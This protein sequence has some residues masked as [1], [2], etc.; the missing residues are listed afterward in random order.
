MAIKEA[1]GT[2]IINHAV[3][4]TVSPV[5]ADASKGIETFE[6]SDSSLA[7]QHLLV[8]RDFG[9]T[10]SSDGMAVHK[11]KVSEVT[12]VVT[13]AGKRRTAVPASVS[14]SAHSDFE[15]EVLEQAIRNIGQYL[16][17]NAVDLSLGRFAS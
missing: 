9:R 6:F 17:D 11:G 16:L 15:P 7:A 5:S 8:R 13:A 10:V 1:N 12:E 2:I 4:V 14:L 3:P